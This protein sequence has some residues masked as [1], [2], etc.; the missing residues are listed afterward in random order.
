MA[1]VNDILFKEYQAEEQK[2]TK[3]TTKAEET[4]N[5]GKLIIDATCCPADIRY[6]NDMSI[7]NEAREK[8]E[9]ILDELYRKLDND[10]EKPRDYRHVARKAF[11]EYTKKR[12]PCSKV[13][14]KAIRKQLQY[15]KRNLKHIK[16]LMSYIPSD[17]IAIALS[18]Q[19]DVLHDVF[20]QQNYMYVN[21][22]N[23]VANRIVSISQPHVRPIVRGKAGKHTEFG[24]KISMSLTDGFCFIDHLSWD[25]FNESGDFKMQVEKYQVEKYKER[26]GYY[27]ESI[28]A[29]KIYLTRKNRK[30]CC[31]KYFCRLTGKP[32]GRPKK[33]TEENQ[34]EKQKEKKQRAQDYID[35]IAIEG[36]FGVG[37]RRYGMDRFKA[38]LPITSES[39]IYMTT[40]VMNLDKMVERDM[41]EIRERYKIKLGKA[42]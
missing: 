5:H 15:L 20:D 39:E 6:P 8:T 26:H 28:H 37:K 29:D 25:N 7:L 33:S 21:R 2:K 1:L 19:L 41:K 14:R 13:R 18:F 11:L 17:L 42:A 12:K 34:E 35:R 3:D 4:E 22:V 32:L 31:E 36:R 10:I 23:R 30:L 38:K 40:V 27:P 24:A 9:K 16:L